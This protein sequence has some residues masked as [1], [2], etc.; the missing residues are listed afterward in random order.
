MLICI[1]TSISINGTELNKHIP[2]DIPNVDFEVATKQQIG[3]ETNTGIHIFKLYC[4]LGACQLHQ[5]SLNECESVG[6]I[7]SSFTLKTH[8]WTTWAGN[9]K[10]KI[11]SNNTLD[12][13]VF[14]AMHHELPAHISFNYFSEL[15]FSKHVKSF[16]TKGFLNLKTYPELTT[17]EYVPIIGFNKVESINCPIML[18]GI[19]NNK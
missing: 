3:N 6:T 17:V 14:Q 16:I 9:L 10:V 5:F 7:N 19:D 11:V 13:T 15:P 4:G 1:F 18:Q 2:T 8:E 12:V